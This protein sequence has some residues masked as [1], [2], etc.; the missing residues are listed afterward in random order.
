MLFLAS[1]SHRGKLH[2]KG[3]SGL[4]SHAVCTLLHSF[5]SDFHVGQGSQ[6]C[7]AKVE[8]H[9][10]R[11]HNDMSGNG[12]PCWERTLSDWQRSHARRRNLFDMLTQ[13]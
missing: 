2:L 7:N 8:H 5:C 11:M 4:G 1:Q 12:E 10:R 6:R 13:S 9:R 3:T